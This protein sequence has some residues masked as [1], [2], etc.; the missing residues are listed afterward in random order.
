MAHQHSPGFLALVNEAKRAI[1]ELT[2]DDF[3]RRAAAGERFILLDVREDHEW[4]AG[5]LPGAVHMS[6]GIIERDIEQAIPDKNAP[7]V[8]QCGGGFR[9]AL[10]CETL[11]RMGYANTWSLA[12]GYRD[13]TEQGLPIE[14]P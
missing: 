7:I 11:Q 13:W 5:R 6:K 2:I 3:R 12:G 4:E 8:C 9:S 14:R 10:V 1:R